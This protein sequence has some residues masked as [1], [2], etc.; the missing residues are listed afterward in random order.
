MAR[1]PHEPDA[2]VPP[3]VAREAEALIAVE[4]S[5]AISDLRLLTALHRS[6]SRMAM[7]DGNCECDVNTRLAH[8]LWDLEDHMRERPVQSD[9]DMLAVLLACT[10]KVRDMIDK[11]EGDDVA[12]YCGLGRV[13]ERLAERVGV[14][15]R[16]V[17]EYEIADGPVSEHHPAWRPNGRM[18][19]FRHPV[20]GAD[21]SLVAKGWLNEFLS[22]GGVIKFQVVEHREYDDADVANLR[23][24]VVNCGE[25]A[26]DDL[27]KLLAR[28]EAADFPLETLKRELVLLVLAALPFAGGLR[29]PLPTP[30]RWLVRHHLGEAKAIPA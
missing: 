23:F 16:E 28:K 8:K 19:V 4:Q 12:T 18:Q 20:F 6:Y 30:S 24:A 9:E 1:S 17:T 27:R 7:T 22:F 15:L 26:L 13:I 21:K 25:E 14:D 11:P 29:Q 2:Y 3:E 5:D 10:D